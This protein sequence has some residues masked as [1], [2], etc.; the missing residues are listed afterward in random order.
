MFLKIP[1]GI[2]VSDLIGLLIIANLI[3]NK[4]YKINKVIIIAFSFFLFGGFLGMFQSPDIVR[5]LKGIIQQALVIFMLYPVMKNYIKDDL[6][7]NKVLIYYK[8][9][10]LFLS[11]LIVLYY[12]FNIDIGVVSTAYAR[13]R[14]I[15]GDTGPNVV[16][17]ILVIGALITLYFTQI[18]SI[19]KN[20][21]KLYIEFLIISFGVFSTASVSGVLLLTIG[22][23]WVLYRYNLK[24][25]TKNIKRLFLFFL[26]GILI[27]IFSYNQ[28]DIVR[29]KIDN[30]LQRVNIAFFTYDDIKS[31]NRVLLLTGFTEYIGRYWI[32]GIGYSNSNYLAEKTIHFPLIAAIVEVG[33]IGFMGVFIMYF[34]PIYRIFK[35]RKT[36]QFD[37][38]TILSVLI[39]IGDMIQPNPNYRS[40]WFAILL[41]LMLIK[42]YHKEVFEVK[43]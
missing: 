7:F 24:R 29:V 8:N 6:S 40:T 26:L 22:V 21:Y 19:E 23:V 12:I 28:Y 18:R 10:V 13:S 32:F 4:R 43:T 20:K 17:R 38:A 1:V 3:I 25:D 39:I 14:T 35:G 34:Y 5:S 16:A 42:T 33:I 9:G 37:I 27:I 31:N 30:T 2:L 15:I 11:I 36:V 41:P